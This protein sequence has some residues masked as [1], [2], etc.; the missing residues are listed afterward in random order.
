[1]GLVEQEGFPVAEIL[2]HGSGRERLEQH[3]AGAEAAKIAAGEH[4][5]FGAL[6]VDL[7][8]IDCLDAMLIADCGERR[9]RHPAGV[10]SR[11]EFLSVAR[12]L[13]RNA[14]KSVEPLDNVEI[15]LAAGAAPEF[16]HRDVARAH[17]GA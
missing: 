3:D 13:D 14:G 8:E 2:R 16:W 9:H 5:A 12:M 6:D 15:D 17:P 7:E 4:V 1:M 11:A 10:E